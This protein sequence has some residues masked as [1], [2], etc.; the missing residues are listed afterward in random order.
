MKTNRGRLAPGAVVLAAGLL[1]GCVTPEKPLYYWGDYQQVVYS[2]FKGGAPEAQRARLEQTAHLA[3]SRGEALPPGFN[4]HLGLLYLNTGQL[5]KA[6]G[7]FQAEAALFP[8][9]RPY[10]EFLLK[11]FATQN[12]GDA[13]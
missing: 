5:D 2:H 4:A 1:S 6:Q 7:A 8:E 3:Q 12:L 13:R 11:K 10:M 9:S